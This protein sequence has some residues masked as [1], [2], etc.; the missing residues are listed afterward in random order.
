MRVIAVTHL[1]INLIEVLL[2]RKVNTTN[3]G[4]L[5]LIQVNLFIFC[6]KTNEEHMFWTPIMPDVAKTTAVYGTI[7]NPTD[8]DVSILSVSS[9]QYKTV[10]FHTITTDKEGIMRMRKIDY[11]IVIKPKESIELSRNGTHLMLYEKE[12]SSGEL[13]IHIHFSNGLVQKHV[14]EKKSL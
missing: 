6:H 14:V 8:S 13:L 10:E 12:N 9:N 11:P 4:I 3:L 7:Q 5:F 1:I 2:L